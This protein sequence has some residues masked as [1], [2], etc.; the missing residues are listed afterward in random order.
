MTVWKGAGSMTHC[1]PDERR[2]L[3]AINWSPIRKAATHAA[4]ILGHSISF[5]RSRSTV[6]GSLRMGTCETCGGCCWIAFTSN[7]AKFDAGGRILRYRCGTD[8]AMGFKV[9]RKEPK[10]EDEVLQESLSK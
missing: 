10:T 7:S 9:A 8:E 3:M 1:T 6:L 4:K 2:A 5:Y